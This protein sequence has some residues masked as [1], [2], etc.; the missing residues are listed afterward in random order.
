MKKKDKL[1][2]LILN[3]IGFRRESKIIIII[4]IIIVGLIG[5]GTYIYVYI[6]LGFNLRTLG[7]P[8]MDKHFH[9]NSC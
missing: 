3:Q 4:I 1:I 2:N 7:N 5:L 6:G 9:K 8:R